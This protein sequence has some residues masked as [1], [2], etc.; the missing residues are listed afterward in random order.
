[1]KK[2][3]TETQTYRVIRIGNEFEIRFYPS[4]TMATIH[5]SAK[6]YKELS[7]FG[8]RK[9][10][11]YI[12]GGNETQQKMAMITPVHMD[13]NDS[14]SSMSFVMPDIYKG[15]PLPS[16]EDSNVMIGMT[17]GEYVAVI[18]FGGFATDKSIKFYSEKLK[19]LLEMNSIKYSGNFRF[20]GYNQP[21]QLMSRRNE[22]IVDIIW[23]LY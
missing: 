12:L 10:A 3:T 4:V 6:T 13:I 18:R 5:S 23:R 7:D 15:T 16:P 22:I 2:T 1:M 19:K 11:R 9:L 8:F 17:S 21:Y 14:I 20:L